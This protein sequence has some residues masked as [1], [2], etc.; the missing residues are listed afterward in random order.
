MRFKK[1]IIPGVI[2]EM[3]TVP[4]AA[5][6]AT[7]QWL[8]TILGRKVGPSTGTN[9]Y[10]ALNIAHEMIQRGETGSIVTLICD[11]GDRYLNCHYNPE[12]LQKNIADL[13]PFKET[14]K[15]FAAVLR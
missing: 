6:V 10:G 15:T 12:W 5:S 2:D 11:S 8:E 1:G 3:R 4:D 13:T 9:L 7:I 14:L